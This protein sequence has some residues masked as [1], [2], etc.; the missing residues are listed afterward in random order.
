MALQIGIGHWT[1]GGLNFE[2]LLSFVLLFMLMVIW[3]LPRNGSFGK[4]E[5]IHRHTFFRVRIKM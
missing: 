4:V 3:G 1:I 5:N 2:L